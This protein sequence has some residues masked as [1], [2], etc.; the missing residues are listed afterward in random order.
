MRSV[1]SAPMPASGSSSSSTR[2]RV[3]RHIATSSW[4]LAPWLSVPAMRS[5]HRRRG[6]PRPALRRAAALLAAQR[7]DDLPDRPRPRRRGLRRE[8]AVLE[9]GELRKDRRALV[10]AA[11]AGARAARLRAR[12][13]VLAVERDAAVGRGDLAREHVDQRRL[14]GAVGADH[15]VHFA[16][17]QVER[18]RVD[19]DQAAEAARERCRLPA[20]RSC[21]SCRSPLRRQR[22][23]R[24]R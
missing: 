4:R 15:R 23:P 3:A 2:G 18:H 17:V 9:H 11:D 12:R 10:A 16:A 8:P 7:C 5:A 1:S 19:R 13:D 22:A 21:G 24:C 6:R 20:G 14:A